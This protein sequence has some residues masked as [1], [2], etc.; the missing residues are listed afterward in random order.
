MKVLMIRPGKRPEKKE[1]EDAFECLQSAVEGYIEEL[2]LFDDNAVIL[3]N[4]EGKTL[5]LEPNR[6]VYDERGEVSDVIFG[7]FLI[8]GTDDEKGNYC[9]LSEEQ[10]AKYEE[11][12]KTPE[13]FFRSGKRIIPVPV[14]Q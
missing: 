12:Y 8:V 6:A 5:G 7:N 9:S 14:E 11:M 1:I 13:R 2:S 3:L 10:L 4:E